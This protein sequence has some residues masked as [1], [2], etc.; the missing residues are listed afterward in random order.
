MV[1]VVIYCFAVVFRV[2][3]GFGV[4]FFE[5]G[6]GYVSKFGRFNFRCSY[7]FKVF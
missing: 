5:G 1:R 3:G 7:V 6:V 2:K 4:V